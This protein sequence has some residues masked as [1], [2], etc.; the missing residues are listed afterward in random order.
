MPV[1]YTKEYDLS[2]VDL[3]EELLMLYVE[4]HAKSGGGRRVVFLRQHE[5]GIPVIIRENYS[6]SGI[7]TPATEVRDLEAVESCFQVIGN[8]LANGKTVCVPIYP[9]TEEVISIEKQSPKV[10]AYL[11]KRMAS[12]NMKYHLGNTT[13]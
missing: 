6:E 13:R 2:L 5:R 7:I 9:L 3:N 8:H 1:L 4:S 10:A 11:R 12:Y